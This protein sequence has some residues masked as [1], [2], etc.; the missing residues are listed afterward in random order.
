MTGPWRIPNEESTDLYPGLVVHD[1]RVSGSITIDAS[2]LPLWCAPFYLA[3]GWASFAAEYAYDDEPVGTV[4]GM[5]ADGIAQF[6]CYLFDQ[7]GEFARLILVLADVER[8]EQERSDAH[9]EEH[10]PGE[11]LVQ[12]DIGDGSGGVPFPKAWW[13]MPDQVE[14]VADMLRRCLAVLEADTQEATP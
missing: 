7:R 3:E 8:I 12:M 11:A 6:L 9:M 2:R 10:A 1:G 5:D 4:Y 13:E 14:R